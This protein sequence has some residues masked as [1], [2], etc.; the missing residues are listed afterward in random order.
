MVTTQL[1]SPPPTIMRRERLKRCTRCG[2]FG[3]KM[4]LD[5]RAQLW[6]CIN[7][8]RT[9]EPELDEL[10]FGGRRPSCRKWGHTRRNLGEAIV[11]AH[12]RFGPD[13]QKIA[14]HLDIP[15]TAVYYYLEKHKKEIGVTVVCL[16]S[17]ALMTHTMEIGLLLVARI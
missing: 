1:K 6:V 2:R 16:A 9:M 5:R 8:G 7:C 11:S 3:G 10:P 15:R 4:F 12:E 17:F 13:P 14:R